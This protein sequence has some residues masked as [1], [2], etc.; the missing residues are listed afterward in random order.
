MAHKIDDVQGILDQMHEE[1]KLQQNISNSDEED[2][3]LDMNYLLEINPAKQ[4][5]KKSSEKKLNQKQSPF[6]IKD[7]PLIML[8]RDSDDSEKDWNKKL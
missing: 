8:E 3:A 4:G 6:K 1:Y 5:S 2:N 7:D